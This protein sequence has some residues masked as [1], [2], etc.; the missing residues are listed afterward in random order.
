M[1]GQSCWKFKYLVIVF[2]FVLLVQSL[3]SCFLTVYLPFITFWRCSPVKVFWF[4]VKVAIVIQN[5]D[6]HWNM[7]KVAKPVRMGQTYLALFMYISIDHANVWLILQ[8]VGAED[9]YW[10]SLYMMAEHNE[11]S[12]C[13][14][15]L[16]SDFSYSTVPSCNHTVAISHLF[17]WIRSTFH[18][19][20]S[21]WRSVFSWTTFYISTVLRQF[22][23]Q[24][25]CSWSQCLKTN[26]YLF[27]KCFTSVGSNSTMKQ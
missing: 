20:I 26:I 13:F 25:V 6:V 24:I 27:S 5:T 8:S 15:Q 1:I 23:S 18:S 16:C 17:I 19:A 12:N 22:S 11:V 4:N 9:K 7:S 10:P 2:W 21:F 14:R 3:V